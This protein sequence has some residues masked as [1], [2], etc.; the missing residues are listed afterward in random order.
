MENDLKARIEKLDAS[1]VAELMQFNRDDIS[2]GNSGET[3][4]MLNEMLLAK[5][6]SEEIDEI[7][8]LIIESGM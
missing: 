6:E 5:F 1:D 2:F 3:R 8:L 4:E 7:E